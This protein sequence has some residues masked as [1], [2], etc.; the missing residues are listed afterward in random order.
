LTDR[1]ARPTLER[2][3]LQSTKMTAARKKKQRNANSRSVA[4]PSGRVAGM[5]APPRVRNGISKMDRSATNP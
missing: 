5:P 4:H 2:I 3:N 1:I